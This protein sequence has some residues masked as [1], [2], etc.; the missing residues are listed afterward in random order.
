MYRSTE[1]ALYRAFNVAELFYQTAPLSELYQA[2][3]WESSA[4]DN[5][6]C[7]TPAERIE[8]DCQTHRLLKQ[9]LSHSDFTLLK[10]IYCRSMDIEE[11]RTGLDTLT[12][13]IK[14]QTGRIQFNRTMYEYTC[15]SHLTHN[16][17]K[18]IRFTS[19]TIK[20]NKKKV[21]SALDGLS[22]GAH[23]RAQCVL[24]D[25]DMVAVQ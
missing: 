4:V 21:C 16:R 7:S 18:E 6:S 1:Q 2:P 3:D 25:R 13:M 8:Q 12:P 20:H 15:I 22:D 11:W 10:I 5:S 17:I 19:S 23:Y 9:S 14:T 24:I